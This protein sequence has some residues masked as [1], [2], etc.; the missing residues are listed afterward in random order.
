MKRHPTYEL[1]TFILC[2]FGLI[3]LAIFTIVSSVHEWKQGR[4][5][6][7]PMNAFYLGL[8]VFGV[9]VCFLWTK[10]QL[11]RRKREDLEAESQASKK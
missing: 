3:L 6:D 1:A 9:V 4:Y 11:R 5:I 2:G 7:L 10:I 8:E